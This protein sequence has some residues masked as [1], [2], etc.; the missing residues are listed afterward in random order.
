VAQNR[1]KGQSVSV[2]V[3]CRSYVLKVFLPE[4]LT[5]ARRTLGQPVVQAQPVASARA[6][7]DSDILTPEGVMVW[8]GVSRDWIAEKRRPRGMHPLPALINRPLRFS[9]KAITAWLEDEAC[10]DAERL[11]HKR[12]LPV[13][14]RKPARK[15]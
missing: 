15:R 8:L 7:T 1:E 12:A 10:R 4:L 14:H 13:R 5:R 11:E 6:N 2:E 9:K 3:Q